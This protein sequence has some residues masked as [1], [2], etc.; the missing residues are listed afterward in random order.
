MCRL[1]L[2]FKRGETAPLKENTKS[3]VVAAQA[4]PSIPEGSH[5]CV[6]KASQVYRA[7]S[8]AAKAEKPSLEKTKKTRKKRKSTETLPKS[9]T[10]PKE[11]SFTLKTKYH[12]YSVDIKCSHRL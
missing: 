4:Y 9:R 8:R 6:F 2:A 10:L 11:A 12:G 5:R 3:Q 7:R 1:F